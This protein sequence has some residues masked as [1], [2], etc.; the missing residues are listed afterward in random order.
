M[1][2]LRNFFCRIA[3]REEHLGAFSEWA[4]I[5]D[6]CIETSLEVC[7]SVFFAQT[8]DSASTLQFEFEVTER[9][10]SRR[11]QQKKDHGPIVDR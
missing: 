5:G 1:L 10:Q 11:V 6:F 8:N 7:E 9:A 2:Q 3:A 4:I